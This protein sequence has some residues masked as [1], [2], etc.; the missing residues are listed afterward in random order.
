[1]GGRAKESER[2]R[3]LRYIYEALRYCCMRPNDSFRVPLA[4]VLSMTSEGLTLSADIVTTGFFGNEKAS[5]ERVEIKWAGGRSV[6]TDDDVK[7]ALMDM[8]RGCGRDA[9]TAI[10]LQA[11]AIGSIGWQIPDNLFL[12]EV[13]CDADIRDWFYR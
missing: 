11:P 5:V 2:E 4:Q 13:P 3:V 10:L 8:L 6:K 7:E 12:N 9:E 1:M